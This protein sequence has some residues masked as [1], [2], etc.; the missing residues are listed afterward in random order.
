MTQKIIIYIGD[1]K[2]EI[3]V[4]DGVDP[5]EVIDQLTAALNSEEEE[6]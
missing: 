5:A 3:E 1:T 4:A 2:Y 6:S